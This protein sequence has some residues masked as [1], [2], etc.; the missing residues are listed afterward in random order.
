MEGL[1]KDL[2]PVHLRSTSGQSLYY[3][4]Y[5]WNMIL[6]SRM[7]IDKLL[8]TRQSQFIWMKVVDQELCTVFVHNWMTPERQIHTLDARLF[9][10]WWK[11]FSPNTRALSFVFSPCQSPNEN[12][13]KHEASMVP[14]MLP[15]KERKTGEKLPS[16]IMKV[17]VCTR[18]LHH[19]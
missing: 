7:S 6:N 11:F 1:E 13:I 19:L 10:D 18:S 15:M 16:T 9:I 12:Y 2:E 3:D 5:L 4:L 17:H 14:I 8:T